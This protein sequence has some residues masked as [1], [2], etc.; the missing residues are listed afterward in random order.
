MD[1]LFPIWLPAVSR[2][3][4]PAPSVETA[5]QDS[6]LLA[7]VHGSYGPSDEVL[8]SRISDGDKEA[9]S[10]LFT[11]Y[12]RIV[13]GIAYRAVRDAAEGG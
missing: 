4:E 12:A 8:L 1:A 3:E 5:T 9:Q 10:L 6:A 7:V 2:A 13:R 11:R